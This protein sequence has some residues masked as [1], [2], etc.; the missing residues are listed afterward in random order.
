MDFKLMRL[1]VV[2][3]VTAIALIIAAVIASNSELLKK[4]NNSS[5]T[6]ESAADTEA[7]KVQATKYGDRIGDNLKAF[8]TDESFFD[9]EET[10][11][12][13]FDESDVVA[14]SIEASGHP[15]SLEAN[16]IN[17]SSGEV[18]EGTAFTISVALSEQTPGSREERVYTDA[19]SDG[20]ITVEDLEEG[21]Y[22]VTLKEASGF[23][24]PTDAVEVYV[25]QPMRAAEEAPPAEEQG[26]APA[27]EQGE[28]PAEEQGEAPPDMQ[29][30]IQAETTEVDLG[31]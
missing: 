29:E 26:E 6:E 18:V 15:G 2:A 14:V 24:V 10:G 31:N 22:R 23:H 28:A 27:D 7:E 13:G 12:T 25:T 20:R 5:G 9:S 4:R 17:N 11:D 8:L 19:D 3:A 21:M 16:I 1:A 30:E